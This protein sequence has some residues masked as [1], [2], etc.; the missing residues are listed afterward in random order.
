MTESKKAEEYEI[1][2]KSRFQPLE[3]NEAMEFIWEDF[4]TATADR[5]H[6]RNGT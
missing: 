1:K 3:G 2:L 5:Y 6:M 4:K